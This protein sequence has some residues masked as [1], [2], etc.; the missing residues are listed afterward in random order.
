MGRDYI[1]DS[2][3]TRLHSSGMYG[4]NNLASASLSCDPSPGR[5]VCVDYALASFLGQGVVTDNVAPYMW[6]PS[7]PDAAALEA[8]FSQWAAFFTAHRPVLTSAAS[9]H[10]VRPTARALEATVHL[11]P[12]A[13]APE[14]A[15]LT[16]YNP[17]SAALADAL[18][19]NLYYAGFAPGDRVTVTD[20][21]PVPGF[22]GDAATPLRAP[23][24]HVV[25]ADGGGVFDVLVAVNMP[26]MS[27]AHLVVTVAAAAAVPTA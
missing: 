21:T 16:V 12:N 2:T 15:L 17:S 22:R 13:T 1:Y 8:I 4:L 9:L 24:T 18:P 6:S 19:L 23:T 11:L 25:G 3:T 10:I 5:L 7:D 27:H 20:V 26:A 14:R